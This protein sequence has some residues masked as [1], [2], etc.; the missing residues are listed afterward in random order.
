MYAALSLADHGLVERLLAESFR[1]EDDV[2]GAKPK[3]SE[4]DKEAIF[5]ASIRDRALEI[6]ESCRAMLN[7]E[8]PERFTDYWGK[9]R[10]CR[11]LG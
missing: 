7:T 4:A 9:V 2:S 5:S 11:N 3:Q 8:L 1:R 6:I 10:Q